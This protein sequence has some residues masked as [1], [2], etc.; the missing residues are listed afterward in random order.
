MPPDHGLPLVAHC[1]HLTDRACAH[2]NLGQ[3][4]KALALLLTV[5]GM[6]PDWI[7]YQSFARAVVQDLLTLERTRSTT[8]RELAKR[9]GANL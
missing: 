6:S 2:T 3:E 9:I 5:E 1:R 4:E 7:R 8:L